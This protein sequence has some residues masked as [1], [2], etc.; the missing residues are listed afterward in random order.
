M[1]HVFLSLAVLGAFAPQIALADGFQVPEG[2]K[3]EVTV[4]MRQ[5]TVANHYTCAGLPQMRFISYADGQGE[6]FL[7]QL[8]A[9]TRWISSFSPETGEEERLDEASPDHASFSTL[10]ATGRDDYDFATQSNL[11]ARYIY[12]GFDKVTGARE[13]IGGVVLEHSEFEITTLDGAGTMLSRRKGDEYFNREMRVFFSGTE[14]FENAVG[15]KVTTSAPP[16]SFAFDGEKGFGADKPEFDCDALLTRN[17][18]DPL[19][20]EAL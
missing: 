8:D 14:H 1:R 7:S 5:C 11:G 10:L 19:S 17:D 20:E 2:C 6:F 15:D 16:A 12:R 3:L 18:Q 13:V 4:Q 9:E